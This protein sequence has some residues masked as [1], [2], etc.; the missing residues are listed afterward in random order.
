MCERESKS[1]SRCDP[2][3]CSCACACRPMR[4]TAA[5]A[6]DLFLNL[7]PPPSRCG[8]QTIPKPRDFGG[9]TRQTYTASR[10]C[11][12]SSSYSNNKNDDG[13]RNIKDNLELD[14]PAHCY[15]DSCASTPHEITTE[16]Y[17][18]RRYLFNYFRPNFTRIC[19]GCVND[20]NTITTDT[21]L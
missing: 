12:T 14:F 20:N 13:H 10:Q 3:V 17:P 21:R 7:P 4:A 16:S 15:D 8:H 2:T 18:F 6:K 19:N 11:R 9:L 5:A 1:V